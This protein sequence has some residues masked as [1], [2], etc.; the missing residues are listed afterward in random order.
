MY[1]SI[2][3]TNVTHIIRD[4]DFP[5]FCSNSAH[6]TQDK[7]VTHSETTPRHD[8]KKLNCILAPKSLGTGGVG[9]S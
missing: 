9:W 4:T 7:V 6:S 8:G 2:F 1:I 3:L 5:L